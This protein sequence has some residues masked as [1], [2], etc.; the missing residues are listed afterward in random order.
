ML[1]LFSLWRILPANAEVHLRRNEFAKSLKIGVSFG[2]LLEEVLDFA[3]VAALAFLARP[4]EKGAGS[5]IRW[6]ISKIFVGFSEVAATAFCRFGQANAT[7]FRLENAADIA[8]TLRR[9]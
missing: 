8:D 6:L 3:A 9:K 4:L 7:M 1:L 5:T 2:A